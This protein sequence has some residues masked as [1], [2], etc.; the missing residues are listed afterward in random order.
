MVEELVPARGMVTVPLDAT[1]EATGAATLALAEPE[2][3]SPSE[4]P[5]DDAD[6]P[7][8]RLSVASLAKDV[9][10]SMVRD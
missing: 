7:G 3:E 9:N 10:D 6:S 2:L 1:P 4:D 8:E 5:E